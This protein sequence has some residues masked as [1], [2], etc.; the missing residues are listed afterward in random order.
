MRAKGGTG[1]ILATS[2]IDHEEL[3][4][5]LKQKMGLS[6]DV[7]Y[8][9]TEIGDRWWRGFWVAKSSGRPRADLGKRI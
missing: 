3:H 5:L 8:T 6:N 9:T 7:P 1:R 4:R 2:K